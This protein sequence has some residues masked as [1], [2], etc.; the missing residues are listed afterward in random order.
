MW[1]VKDR[2]KFIDVLDHKWFKGKTANRH[3]AVQYMKKSLTKNEEIVEVEEFVLQ[4]LTKV[5]LKFYE[6]Q[7]QEFMA[8][9]TQ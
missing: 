4:P 8:N 6:C 9:M 1:D 5:L 7:P 2:I 3:D